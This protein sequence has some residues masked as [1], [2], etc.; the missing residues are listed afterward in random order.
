MTWTDGVRDGP[1][2]GPAPPPGSSHLVLVSEA[3]YWVE[4][5]AGYLGEAAFAK[6][7]CPKKSVR[8]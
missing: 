2:C 5:L 1:G 7:H 6:L 3:V 8:R 4:G